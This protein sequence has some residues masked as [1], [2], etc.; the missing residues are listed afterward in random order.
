MDD[1]M[2]AANESGWRVFWCDGGMRGPTVG[3]GIE[4]RV[5]LEQNDIGSAVKCSHEQV[6]RQIKEKEKKRE[7]EKK[8]KTK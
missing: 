7:G 2:K 4:A 5:A 8:K 3:R 1:V 6:V